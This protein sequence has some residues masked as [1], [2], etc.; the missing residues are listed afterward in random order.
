MATRRPYR[1]PEQMFSVIESWQQ[2][3]LSQSAFCQEH[4]LPVHIL[5]Y[6]FRKYNSTPS[7]PSSSGFIPVNIEADAG[8]QMIEIVYP[9]GV[10]LRLPA[11]A[12]VDI[13]RSLVTLNC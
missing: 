13:I 12:G 8:D 4:D 5:C 1:T 9:T 3:G 11:T 7:K 2:S 10:L 6:W